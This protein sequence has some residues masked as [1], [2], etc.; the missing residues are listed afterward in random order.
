M[1]RAPQERAV[2]LMKFKRLL[3]WLIVIYGLMLALV[4]LLLPPRT[5]FIAT[6]ALTISLILSMIARVFRVS[7]SLACGSCDERSVMT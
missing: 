2:A 5:M 3:A 7:C 4:A 1:A 6:E